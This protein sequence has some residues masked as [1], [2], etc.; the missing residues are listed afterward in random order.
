MSAAAETRIAVVTGAGG[1]L[2][3][4]L[5]LEL[6]GR[7][8]T[9]AGLGR[10]AAPLEETAALVRER[11][12]AGSG[13]AR[14]LPLVADVADPAAV[15][16]AFDRIDD[17]GVPRILINNAAIYEHFDFLDAP[18][19]AFMRAVAVNLG[20]VVNCCHAAL[21]RMTRDGA[22][23]IVNVASFADLAPLPASAAYS[24]SKGAARILTRAL[25]ADL[26]DRFPDIVITD[27]APGALATRMG[28]PDGLPPE[29]A[30]KWGAALALETDPALNGRVFE[31]DRELP[32]PR[33][34]KGR[35]KDLVLLRRPPPPRVLE[36]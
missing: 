23:R 35:I 13:D 27:W 28:L 3:R 4:A 16:A 6:A 9:V 11:T 18:P 22:G 15:A 25:V 34:L 5:T 17:A 33:G 24:V 36:G 21:K 19:E 2:G 31:R 20:G 12:G 7:G 1:G 30:A 8:L 32:P 29:T 26:A 14:F 10:R